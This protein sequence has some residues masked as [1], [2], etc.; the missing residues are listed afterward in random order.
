M[1]HGQGLLFPVFFLTQQ[2]PAEVV[3]DL[4]AETPVGVEP[5]KG[6]FAGD[7]RGQAQSRENACSCRHFTVPG[8]FC[9]GTQTV[10]TTSKN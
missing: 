7:P 10:A 5:T 8:P 2:L 4:A 9:K 1:H 3:D 6:R